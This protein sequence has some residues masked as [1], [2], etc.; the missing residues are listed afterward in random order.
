MFSLITDYLLKPSL[1][2]TGVLILAILGIYALYHRVEHI[3]PVLFIFSFVVLYDAFVAAN[4][5][6]KESKYNRE[7]SRKKKNMQ[8]KED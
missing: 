6:W 4:F 5:F 1:A 7:L 3:N 8:G 2:A